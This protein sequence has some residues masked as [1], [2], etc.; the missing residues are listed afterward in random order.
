M[1]MQAN[2]RFD[3]GRRG[4]SVRS[5]CRLRLVALL[6]TEAGAG[7]AL[8][9]LTAAP[10]RHVA[11]LTT[12]ARTGGQP[13]GLSVVVVAVAAV[14]TWVALAFLVVSTIAAATTLVARQPSRRADAASRLP[15]TWWLQRVVL[16]ACGVSLLSP[17]AADATPA[18]AG[19]PEPH[20]TGSNSVDAPAGGAG[21]LGTGSVVSAEEAAQPRL[22]GLAMPDLPSG[23]L[24]AAIHIIR[25]G[26]SLWDIAQARLPARASEAA[27]SRHVL[28]V[29]RANRDVIGSDP[30]LIYPGTPLVLPGGKP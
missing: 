3:T 6:I 16:S 10:L 19:C 18:T 25:S 26:D 2:K 17:V 27:I 21:V 14:V 11:A 13:I 8:Y 28:A 20:A 9:A 4:R 5:R 1:Q 7:F 23:R 24:D 12:D 15:R 29:Y 22:T 30:D